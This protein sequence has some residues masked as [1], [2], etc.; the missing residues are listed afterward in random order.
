MRRWAARAGRQA[1]TA[2]HGLVAWAFLHARAQQR[3]CAPTPAHAA[4]HPLDTHAQA[5][6]SKVSRW[7]HA[8]PCGSACRAAAACACVHARVPL[9]CPRIPWAA[10]TAKVRGGH[11]H[12][13][14]ANCARVPDACRGHPLMHCVRVCARLHVCACAPP[15][16]RAPPRS[17][18]L[19][20]VLGACYLPQ[21]HQSTPEEHHQSS[22]G[23]PSCAVSPH[24]HSHTRTHAVLPHSAAA[25]AARPLI[26]TH[27]P[28]CCPPSPARRPTLLHPHPLPD[29]YT[30]THIHA[31]VLRSRGLSAGTP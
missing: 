29:T 31:A 8:R 25:A 19:C 4:P 28:L 13:P 7:V 11:A 21:H 17:L 15:C 24:A 6:A 10:V 30:H 18:H 5:A 2:V 22:I 12:A 3:A 16:V 1:V 26:R 9:P 14:L 20:W 23:A 27:I